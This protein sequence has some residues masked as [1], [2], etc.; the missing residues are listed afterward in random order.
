MPSSVSAIPVS[1]LY[2][3]HA[4]AWLAAGFSLAA[5]LVLTG[6]VAVATAEV[7]QKQL[8]QR[9]EWLAGERHSRIAEL[10]SDQV[11]RLESL[12]N[13]FLFSG[14]VTRRDFEGFA[15][16]LLART[17]AYAWAPVVPH[18]QRQAWEQR[19]RLEV[20][21]YRILQ[22]NAEGRL[23]SA[24]VRERYVPVAYLQ[25]QDRQLSPLGFDLYS[26]NARRDTLERA[27][28]RDDVAVSVPVDLISLDG[29]ERRGLILAAPVSDLRST[30]PI[31]GYVTAVI[32]MQHLMEHTLTGTGGENLSIDIV[33]LS[34][35]GQHELLYR[36]TV[37]AAPSALAV[38]Y[39]LMLGD[40]Q[41][42]LDVRPSELFIKSNRSTVVG[43]VWLCGSLLSVLLSTLLYSLVSQRRRAWQ[44][45]QQRTLQLRFS[46]QEL[47]GTHAQLT[48][49]LKAATQ[50]GI[51]ATDLDGVV[52]TF[53][54]GAELIFGQR[55]EDVIGRQALAAL[56]L[57]GE[58]W[59][60]T[61]SEASGD[62]RVPLE[63]PLERVDGSQLLIAL[64]TAPMCDEE[65]VCIGHLAICLDITERKRVHEALAAR[66]HLLEKLSAQVPGGLYLY[67]ERLDGSSHFPY[68][69]AGLRE[70]FEVP[71]AVL[72]ETADP[73]FAR[74]HEDELEQVRQ[75]FYLA[76]Q[77]LTPWREEFRVRLPVK[78]VRWIRGEATPERAEDGSTVWYGY[79][80]DIS[81]LKRVEEELRALT[82][83]DSLT[84]IHNRRY[85]QQRL[86]SEL[87]R[88]RRG[89]SPLAVIMLDV[90]YFKRIND[91]FG[92][93]VGDQVLQ[94]LCR[95]VAGR[96]RRTDVF[97]RLGGEEF[98][99]LCPDSTVEQAFN[100]AVELWGSVR[101]A[102]FEDVGKVT[103]SFGVAGWRR[104]E[105]ADTL[106]LRADSGVYAAKQKGRDRVEPEM[107]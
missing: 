48:S 20:P 30:P 105:G 5:G 25:S 102:T 82:V 43:I 15:R 77:G 92:H 95:L 23:Q 1:G 104:D 72:R 69:S 84:G 21:G 11:L 56:R 41:Y 91:Q 2:R 13:F 75:S 68:A 93:A 103:A 85:F 63:W 70:V 61:A 6:L 81:D 90:D 38:H 29:E 37:A 66:D 99:V 52:T 3:K 100:L 59:Q 65:G 14:A 94:S 40:R 35:A 7:Y 22:Q 28:E 18:A 106:L 34:S 26:Q 67:R 44:L 54:S 17:L 36:S 64:L 53:N 55:A 98:I 31:Q 9:F 96:L 101:S 10:F 73:S 80:T 78:G 19:M 24:S 89:S 74:I 4:P 58:L 45:V 49:V 76:R 51:V 27:R 60:A 79:L 71:L 88:A 97:C 107:R 39:Q 12:R 16:P 42:G 83:T 8:R 86:R 32:S 47:R 62:D 57:P 50:V 33:D 87:D 46:E